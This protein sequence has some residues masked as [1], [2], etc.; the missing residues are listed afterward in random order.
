MAVPIA[1][2]DVSS[3]NVRLIRAG[4]GGLHGRSSAAERPLGRTRAERL[5]H[6]P[7][8]SLDDQFLV[9]RDVSVRHYDMYGGSWPRQA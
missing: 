5:A 2:R 6:R 9:E 4:P 1:A 8:G 3:R 7:G